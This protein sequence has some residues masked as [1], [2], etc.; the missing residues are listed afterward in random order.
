MARHRCC[1]VGGGF[2][3]EAKPTA[4]G[5]TEITVTLVNGN[6]FNTD[7]LYII[8]QSQLREKFVDLAFTIS[9]AMAP[10]LAQYFQIEGK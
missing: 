7:E 5:L 10:S 6:G 2:K 1:F 9:P 4:V 8:S 3:C